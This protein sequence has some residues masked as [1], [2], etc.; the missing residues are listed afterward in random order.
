MNGFSQNGSGI[1]LGDFLD[2][3]AASGAGHE[4][5]AAGGAIDEQAEIEFALDVQA[6]FDEQALDDT[7]GGTGL[8]SDQLHAENLAG[9]IGSFV[10]RTGQLHAS[11]FA[12]AAGMDLRFD[13]GDVGLQALGRFARFFLGEGDFA[14]GSGYA[15]PRQNRFRLVLMNL[16]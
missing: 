16:H 4:Y 10:G 8:R 7:A 6:F 1:F 2:F 5:D 9:E 11:R 14:A 13:D 15:I 3:H 12:A